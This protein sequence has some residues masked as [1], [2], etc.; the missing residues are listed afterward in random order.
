MTVARVGAA[1][2]TAAAAAG[3]FTAAFNQSP[4]SGNLLVMGVVSDATSITTCTT[5]TGWTA[6]PTGHGASGG[7][8]YTSIFLFWKV[9]SGGDTAPSLTVSSW[10]SVLIEEWSGLTATPHDVDST[11]GTNNQNSTAAGT[12]DSG[13]LTTTNASDFIWS[14]M[15]A[16]TGAVRTLT[17][18]GGSTVDAFV[19]DVVAKGFELGT[20]TQSVSSTG[21]YTPTLAFASGSG[22]WYGSGTASMAFKLPSTAVSGFIGWGIPA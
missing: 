3:T 11:V 20:A 2:Y 19:D 10:A 1:K 12:C 7:G 6:G 21:T 22:V 17:W 13:P 14:F 9:A 4:T 8:F 5:P 15:G 18:G 16:P